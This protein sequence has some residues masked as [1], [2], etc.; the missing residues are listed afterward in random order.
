MA[1]GWGADIPLLNISPADSGNPLVNRDV[2][3]CK[4]RSWIDPFTPEAY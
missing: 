3:P 2:M 4:I 1:D